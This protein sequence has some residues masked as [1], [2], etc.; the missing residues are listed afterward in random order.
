MTNTNAASATVELALRTIAEYPAPEQDDMQAANMRKIARE[1]LASPG[2][3]AAPDEDT[4]RTLNGAVR[5]E[6]VE[7]LGCMGRKHLL[8]AA[9]T[10]P[11]VDVV[12]LLF[13]ELSEND[14]EAQSATDLRAQVVELQQQLA[15]A[16]EMPA[17]VAELNR[18][19]TT[20]NEEI[21][22]LR[23]ALAKQGAG[24]VAAEPAAWAISYDGK[25]PYSLWHYGDGPLLD[26]EI[27]RIGG[28]AQK[29]ALAVVGQVV[30]EPTGW[31]SVEAKMP[32][33]GEPVLLDIGKKTPIRA[34]WAAKHTV[35]A[36][37]EAEPGWCDYDESTD[38]HYCPEGWYEWNEH[39]EVHW[40]VSATP[41]AWMCL[42][43]QA[44]KE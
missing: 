28:T 42:P 41:R 17:S 13:A 3:V 39:E 10:L 33:P 11:L 30:A 38:T 32:D 4:A 1:A 20:D 44:P 31:I 27:A 12:G 43:A 26:A 6:I 16:A 8:D 37:D 23:L 19:L 35:E 34:M 9:K 2:A 18:R 22:V 36:H 25:T 5:A 29:M 14:S 24:A 15:D 21:D 7:M 40:A